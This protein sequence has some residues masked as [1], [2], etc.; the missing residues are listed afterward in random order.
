MERISNLKFCFRVL[1]RPETKADR[2]NHGLAYTLNFLIKPKAAL[3]ASPNRPVGQ[4]LSQRT[5]SLQ[6]R[7]W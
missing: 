5:V 7:R 6:S 4:N 3:R 1:T 2:Q